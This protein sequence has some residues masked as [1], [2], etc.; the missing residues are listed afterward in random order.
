MTKE[1]TLNRIILP[2]L[3]CLE[4]GLFSNS[5]PQT[6]IYSLKNPSPVVTAVF[7]FLIAK[8]S[9][10]CCLHSKVWLHV[11]E[12]TYILFSEVTVK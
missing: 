2:F 12:L 5:W 8:P 9:L 6:L 10:D 4:L 7:E 11:E 1:S 3:S